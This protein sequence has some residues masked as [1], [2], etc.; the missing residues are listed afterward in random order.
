M[1][2]R[3]NNPIDL[4]NDS[5]YQIDPGIFLQVWTAVQEKENLNDS[6]WVSLKLTEGNTIR[7][8]NRKYLGRDSETDVIAFPADQDV[9]PFLGDIIIAV[10][11]AAEQMGKNSLEEELQLLFLHGLLHLLG[12]DHFSETREKEMYTKQTLYLNGIKEHRINNGP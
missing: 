4:T 10:D 7:N 6:A 9:L 1:N 11:R 5:N 2:T 8:L 12:Y 3:K